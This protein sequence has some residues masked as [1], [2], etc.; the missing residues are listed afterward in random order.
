MEFEGIRHID[1]PR[2]EVWARLNSPQVM[3]AAIPGCTSFTG[4]HEDGYEA[5]VRVGIGPLRAHFRGRVQVSDV[6]EPESYRL[7]AHGEGPL[8]GHAGG[9][10]DVRL[11]EAGDGTELHY[12]ITSETGGRLGSFG[13]ERIAAVATRLADGFFARLMGEEGG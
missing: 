1:A 9:Q 13:R 3:R 12:R 7:D 8:L 10:A 11:V 6:V 5:I 2:A 4:S